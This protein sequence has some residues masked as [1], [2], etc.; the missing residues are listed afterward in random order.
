MKRKIF[1]SIAAVVL[2]T[3]IF[4]ALSICLTACEP[5][6]KTT[7]TKDTG[8]VTTPGTVQNTIP[9]TTPVNTLYGVYYNG[10]DKYDYR[11]DGFVYKNDVKTYKYGVVNNKLRLYNSLN[12][13][14]GYNDYDYTIGE[15]GL[16]YNGLT[17]SKTAPN[18]P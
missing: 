15:S 16:A 9:N 2:S 7:D 13:A 18:M 8:I 1:L 6:K 4:L 14:D 10:A 12:D 5:N 11:N 3:A 17:Y